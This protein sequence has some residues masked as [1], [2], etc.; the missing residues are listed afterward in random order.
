MALDQLKQ[1]IF[2]ERLGETSVRHRRRHAVQRQDVRGVKAG[3][4]ARSDTQQRDAV[5]FA[6]DPSLADF[7]RF[8]YISDKSWT[9]AVVKFLEERF[10]K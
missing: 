2:V 5:A 6:H 3:F 9:P 10:P 7:K 8:I 4:Q 1:Q